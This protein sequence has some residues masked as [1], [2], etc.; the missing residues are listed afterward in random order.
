MGKKQGKKYLSIY[1]CVCV[2]VCVCV[3]MYIFMCLCITELLVI[4]PKKLRLMFTRKTI[5]GLVTKPRLTLLDR[6]PSGSSVHGI[7]Q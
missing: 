7:L 1:I 6:S 3:C 2:C 5:C 4:H